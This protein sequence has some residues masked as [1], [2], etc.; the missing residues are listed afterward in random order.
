LGLRG[1][2]VSADL[3]EV[4]VA[5][6]TESSA[7]CGRDV[8]GRPDGVVEDGHVGSAY[9]FETCEAVDDLGLELSVGDF[10]VLGGSDFDLYFVFLGDARDICA[11]G[12]EVGGD[13]ER[14]DEAEVNYVA[15]EG[16]IVTVA[17]GGEDIGFGEHALCTPL[18]PSILRK[19]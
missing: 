18:L 6:E 15:G 19:V 16:W 1:G 7:S 2:M 17:E 3:D 13:G 11:G 9:G 8:E 14:V 4:R 5:V 12:F 10:V